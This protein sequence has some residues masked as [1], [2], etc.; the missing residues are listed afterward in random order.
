MDA[1]GNVKI[2]VAGWAYKDWQ[3]IVYPPSLK[4]NARVE[5]LA[6]FFDLIEINTSFY[7]HIKPAVGKEWCR[8][9]ASENPHFVFTAKLNRAFTHSP[10]AV[11]EPTSAKTIR[12]AVSDESDAKAG[13]DAI[14]AEGM[15]GALLAQ[16]PISS[17]IAVKEI[18]PS[19]NYRSRPKMPLDHHRRRGFAI[20]WLTP[21][22]S[23]CLRPFSW[24]P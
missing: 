6:Q 10:V 13:Y 16:F 20:F 17:G 21:V 12:P 22:Y 8:M 9:A 18:C 3:G 2:G 14:A 19:S 15:L 23:R 7:G 24:P 4:A 11:L 1:R 5:Y